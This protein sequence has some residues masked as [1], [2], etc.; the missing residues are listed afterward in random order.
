MLTHRTREAS[1]ACAGAKCGLFDLA[2][3]AKVP[4]QTVDES[5][6]TIVP[7]PDD[8]PLY[9]ARRAIYPQSVRGTYRNIKWAVLAVTL[10][11]YYL[12]PFVRWDR[13]PTSP[14]QAVLIDFANRRFYFFFI[15]I[16]AAGVSIL[17]GC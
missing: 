11:I 4:M 17:L 3:A 16:F 13:G 5:V 8:G 7:D 15:E 12:L 6:A 1:N 9:E 10:G 14:D 2:H